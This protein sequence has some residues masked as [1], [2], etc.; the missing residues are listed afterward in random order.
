MSF[1]KSLLKELNDEDTFLTSMVIPTAREAVEAYV[2]KEDNGRIRMVSFIC[3]LMRSYPQE[4][5]EPILNAYEAIR[6]AR[7]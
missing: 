5:Y 7:A 3:E 1:L 2:R 4:L 6:D